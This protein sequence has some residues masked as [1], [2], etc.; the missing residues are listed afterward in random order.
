MSQETTIPQQ[1]MPPMEAAAKPMDEQKMKASV[2]Q[3]AGMDD[4]A[5][6]NMVNMMKSNPSMMRA[7]Y[8]SQMGTKLSDD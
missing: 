3:L 1:Q 5:M 2:E 7:Q 4:S 8:E 6:E